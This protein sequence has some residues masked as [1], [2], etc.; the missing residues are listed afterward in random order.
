MLTQTQRDLLLF[1]EKRIED[2][3]EAP[4]NREMAEHMGFVLSPK[5]ASSNVHRL[6]QCLK[7]RGYIVAPYGLPR[8]IIVVRPVS[9]FASFKFND[10]TK[11][12]EFN[13]D[14]KPSRAGREQG[15]RAK[16]TREG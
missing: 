4:S 9:R 15:L 5:N 12:L 14:F 16:C 11:E 13:G 6:I 2:T 10:R 3:G 8:S 1:I 7:D